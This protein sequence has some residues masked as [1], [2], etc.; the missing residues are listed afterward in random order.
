MNK[1][2]G[3]AG[4]TEQVMSRFMETRPLAL[5]LW[6]LLCPSPRPVLL[7]FSHRKGTKTS[8]STGE[9]AHSHLSVHLIVRDGSYWKQMLPLSR[10]GGSTSFMCV[11]LCKWGIWGW[12]YNLWERHRASDNTCKCSKWFYLVQNKTYILSPNK[13]FNYNNISILDCPV[14]G[15]NMGWGHFFLSCMFRKICFCLHFFLEEEWTVNTTVASS[16]RWLGNWLWHLLESR[17]YSRL[18][19]FVLFLTE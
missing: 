15:N 12:N 19:V 17:C 14:P 4:R 9:G 2:H 3:P 1:E 5:S 11:I 7:S 10:R 8:S 13:D 16:S 18:V 6:K